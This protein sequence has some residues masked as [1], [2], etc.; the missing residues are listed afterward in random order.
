[1]KLIEKLIDKT[2]QEAA[3]TT[4]MFYNRIRVFIHQNKN[5][6]VGKF[7]ADGYNLTG[8]LHKA[9]QLAE[10]KIFSVESYCRELILRVNPVN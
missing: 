6:G 4:G 5:D 2:V 1:M 3:D 8:I 9:P 7:R 10:C